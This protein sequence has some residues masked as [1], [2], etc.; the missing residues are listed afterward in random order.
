MFLTKFAP[1]TRAYKPPPGNDGK[2][3]RWRVFPSLSE[4]RQHFAEQLQAEGTTADLGWEE[5]AEWEAEDGGGGRDAPSGTTF[6]RAARRS[7]AR[8]SP[9]LP[10]H[11]R[12]KA[13]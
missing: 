4:C 7:G 5:G 10:G 3:E 6:L 9:V 8:E 2:R 13:A 12:R 1:I 11:W